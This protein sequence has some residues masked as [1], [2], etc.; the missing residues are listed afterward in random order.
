MYQNTTIIPLLHLNAIPND[1]ELSLVNKILHHKN[2]FQISQHLNYHTQSYPID[3]RK[4]NCRDQISFKIIEEKCS[5]RWSILS[6][7]CL[8]ITHS[9]RF[10]IIRIF[11][12][13]TIHAKRVT[14]R[15][16][17]HNYSSI[18][19]HTHKTPWNAPFGVTCILLL[20]I[21]YHSSSNV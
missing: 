2:L 7:L 5:R 13:T 21:L 8:H 12:K 10:S 3:P 14:Y 9:S 4:W 6:P 18:A 1:S 19:T 15:E 17:Q 16:C 11:Q 20:A